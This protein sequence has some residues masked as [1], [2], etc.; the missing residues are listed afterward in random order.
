LEAFRSAAQMFE[1]EDKKIAESILAIYAYTR[2]KS[3]LFY[4]WQ[5]KLPQAETST[6]IKTF[7]SDEQAR[8]SLAIC[9][10]KNYIGHYCRMHGFSDE[11][12][13]MLRS[14]LNACVGNGAMPDMSGE[15]A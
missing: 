8:E 11:S 14:M 12:E 9:L 4:A 13:S 15:F 2:I 6:A 10:D 5:A 1:G 3:I 7:T